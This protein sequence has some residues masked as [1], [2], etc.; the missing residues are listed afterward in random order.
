[1]LVT[2]GTT[3]F[4]AALK[5]ALNPAGIA[6]RVTSVFCHGRPQV[7]HHSKRCELGDVLFAVF[8]TDAHGRTYRNSLLAQAKMSSSPV[9]T[10]APSD[11]DQ[12]LLYCFWGDFTYRRTGGGLSN[13]SRTVSPSAP[14][15]GAQYL[16]I[17]DRGPG[18]AATGLTGSP[19]RYPMGL[20]KAQRHLAISESLGLGILQ[21]LMGNNGRSFKDEP[22]ATKDWDQVVWDLLR[23]GIRLFNQR[24]VGILGRPRI[25]D[26]IVN[27]AL[28]FPFITQGDEMP[29]DGVLAAI[30]LAESS[31]DLPPH[32]RHPDMDGDERGASLVIIETREVDVSQA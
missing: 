24:K 31:G 12:L 18:I 6:V 3:R 32:D 23:H 10:V 22:A 2:V 15:P 30:G 27:F 17:D 11:Y 13:Q 14:H 19:G 16:L 5:S 8:H 4:A 29:G 1:M 20:A 9:H 25:Y 28:Q 7:E 21:L 26:V